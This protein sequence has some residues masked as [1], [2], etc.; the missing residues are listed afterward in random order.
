V[1]NLQKPISV[2]ILFAGLLFA[3]LLF[4]G[5]LAVDGSIDA[6]NAQ[7]YWQVYEQDRLPELL[8]LAEKGDRGAQFQLG[9]KYLTGRFTK[10]D[11]A[12]GMR[13]LRASAEQGFT[14]AQLYL[15][16]YFA[17]TESDDATALA[18]LRRAAENTSEREGAIAA[19]R[20]G[21]MLA[22]AGAT[23][24]EAA[25]YLGRAAESGD[26]QAQVLLGTL[27]L[28]GRGVERSADRGLAWIERAATAK[29]VPAGHVLTFVYA[30]GIG[31]S[32]DPLA[33][34]ARSTGAGTRRG[35]AD[36]LYAIGRFYH[37]G[38]WIAREDRPVVS[39]MLG[40]LGVPEDGIRRYFNQ[41]RV[42]A[43]YRWADSTRAIVWYRKAAA[44]GHIGAQ[45]NLGLIHLDFRD[46]N[47]NCAEG[48][49]WT[50]MAA[51]RGDPTAQL[52]LGSFYLA[53][54][55]RATVKIGATG[56]NVRDG[57]QL[58]SVEADG[59]AARAGLRTGDTIVSINGKPLATFGLEDLMAIVQES[60]GRKLALLVKREGE[61]AVLALDVV[62]ERTALK[63]PGAEALGLR[64][65][66]AEAFRWYEK[67][68]DGGHPSGLFFLARAYREGKGVATD[69]VKAM[70][71]YRKGA[72]RGD[73]QAA[74]AISHMYAAGEG[75]A[76]SRELS[77]EWYRKAL[78]L[79]HRSVGR[80]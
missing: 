12:E 16:T 7:P 57:V 48:V 80:N 30:E 59:A 17:D 61:S 2:A 40:Q 32:P 63:C 22:R 24:A 38:F 28:E 10:K 73:W 5:L 74:E 76:K 62:P 78:Q 52:N 34:A 31:R 39:W 14:K 53:G 8:S 54:P 23:S 27:Y 47:W 1:L 43:D 37:Q 19:R 55:D 66:P 9:T 51:D 42:H 56:D 6:A 79:K 29:Y 35:A 64:V 77:E 46:Q 25:R 71:L 11:P 69:P 60:A 41:Q 70:E 58:Q 18:W 20:A 68:A 72:D 65:D 45:V 26:L 50:R 15:G 44:A 36:A 21:V 33:A 3:G 13:W 49:K 75:V 4:A 67:S